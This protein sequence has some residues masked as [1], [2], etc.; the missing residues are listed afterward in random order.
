[1][2]D[3]MYPNDIL[4]DSLGIKMEPGMD[5][6]VTSASV[7]IP[8]KRLHDVEL[9]FE[10]TT[11]PF[12]T[13][14]PMVSNENTFDMNYGGELNTWGRENRMDT[15][16]MDEDF[17][18]VDKSDLIQGPTLAELNGNEDQ[19][20]IGDVNFDDFLMPGDTPYSLPP[21]MTLHVDTTSGLTVGADSPSPMQSTSHLGVNSSMVASSFPPAGIGYF[22]DSL[23]VN[24]SSS[25]PSSPLDIYLP[26]PGSTLSPSSQH[27]SGSSPVGR[28]S[29]LHELL[30]KREPQGRSVPAASPPLRSLARP[31]NSSRLSSSAPTHL[32]LEQ[33]WQRR[34]PRQ[35]LLST[36]SLAEAE[37]A[38]SLSTLGILSPESHD[39]SQDEAS[40][41]E[42]ESD[43]PELE[44]QSSDG[45]NFSICN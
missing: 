29:T 37:S 3:P 20:L 24:A 12:N 9:G 21:A 41:S 36:G 32:G 33:I 14:S 35:H 27:S 39:F 17:F 10:L 7:P 4:Y 5:A 38:S 23:S 13:S 8:Q 26:H 1:M 19:L 6:L 16:Q 25:V 2:A 30:M 31:R 18:Q 42:E 40:D 45:G 11:D 22:K 15:F 43:V 34:E 28:H 44:D